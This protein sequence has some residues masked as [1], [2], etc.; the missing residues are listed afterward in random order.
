MSEQFEMVKKLLGSVLS[1]I[2]GIIVIAFALTVDLLWLFFGIEIL[3][4]RFQPGQLLL[5]MLLIPAGVII[6]IDS[7]RKRRTGAFSLMLVL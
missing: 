1:I 4:I 7:L 2:L 3:H 6:M 5:G